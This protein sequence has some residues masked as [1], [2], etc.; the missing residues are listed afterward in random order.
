MVQNQ[1]GAAAV[2]FA[3][4][5]LPLVTLIL[6][7]A[8]FGYLLYLQGSAA[9]AAREGA[10]VMAITKDE[11]LARAAAVSYSPTPAVVTFSS[12]CGPGASSVTAIVTYSGANLTGFFPFMPDQ[13]I[14]TGTMRCGG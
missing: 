2:E 3:L 13:A 4:I 12:T 8:E 6:G 11:G 9:G 1:R 14:G 10:R 7:G 5:I